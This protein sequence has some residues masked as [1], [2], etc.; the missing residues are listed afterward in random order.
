VTIRVLPGILGASEGDFAWLI[1]QIYQ[2][3]SLRRIKVNI[4]IHSS[5]TYSGLADTSAP[6]S[7]GDSKLEI[8][9]KSSGSVSR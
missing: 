4:I 5:I 3:E 2:A 6:N 8:Y 1:H 7:S 9:S